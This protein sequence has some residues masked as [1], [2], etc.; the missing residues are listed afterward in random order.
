MKDPTTDTANTRSNAGIAIAYVLGRNKLST[1]GSS[2]KGYRFK[3]R[4]CLISSYFPI[5]RQEFVSLPR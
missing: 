4:R 2:R 5:L 1:A 3:K